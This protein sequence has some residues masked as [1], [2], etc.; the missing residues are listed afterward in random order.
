MSI[1]TLIRRLMSSLLSI[2]LLLNLIQVTV[3]VKALGTDQSA[4]PDVVRSV[5]LS[6]RLKGTSTFIDLVAPYEI[7]DSTKI[8][9]LHARY[10]F[11]LLDNVDPVSGEP[12]RTMEGGDFYLIDLPVNVQII[13]PVNGVILG[14]D[15]RP[16]ANY[17]FT[18]KPDSSWQIK[19]EFTTYIDDLNEFEIHG[20]MEFD[21]ILDLSAVA[22]GTTT[23][24]YI[25]IDNENNLEIEVTKPVPAPTTPISLTKTITSYTTSTRDLVWNI[26]MMPDIGKFSGTTFTD[27]IDPALME[28]RSLRHGAVNLV[29][30]TDYTYDPLSGL[31]TY[32]I[33]SGRDGLAFQNIILTT[34]VK[35]SVYGTLTPTL[36]NNQARLTGGDGFV[37]LVSNTATQTIT[38]NWFTKSGSVVQGNRIQW[39]FDI[40]ANTQLMTNAV[41]T[42]VLS[43]NLTL[44]V[45]SVRLGASVVPVYLDAHTPLTAS[46]VYAVLSQHP[47]GTSTLQVFLPRGVAAASTTRQTL[48]L[49]TSVASPTV[50]TPA[51]P[52][53]ANSAT[54]TGDL[55]LEDN[56]LLPLPEIGSGPISVAV[57]HV[58]LNKTTQTLSAADRRNGT[59]TWLLSVASNLASYGRATIVDTLPNDQDYLADEIY[60]GATKLDATTNPSAIISADGRTLTI[61]F[62]D[63]M[64]WTTQQVISVKTKIKTESYGLNVNRDFLNTARAAIY[65][66]TTLA[67]LDAMSDTERIRIQNTVISK[68]AQVYNGNTTRQGENPRLNFQITINANLMPLQDLIVTD[69]LTR[70]ITEFKRSTENTFSVISGLEW[71]YVEDSLRIVRSAGTLDALDLNAI[72]AN[73]E[74]INDVLTVDFGSGVA[75]NDRYTLTFT[76]EVDVESHPI[77][78]TNG[79]LRVRGNVGGVQALGLRSGVVQSTATG[80]S[81][82]IRNEILGK[83]GVHSVAEQQAVWT[84]NLNQ[85]RVSL[86]NTRVVDMLPLGLTLDPTSIKLYTNVIGTN[87]NFVTGNTILTQGVEVPF[88]YTYL[89]ATGIGNEGRYVLSVN[90]PD[91]RTAYILRFATDVSPTLL[92]K[93]ITNEAYFIGDETLPENTN[94]TSL[95]FSSSS[96]GGSVTKASVTVRKTSKDTGLNVD[97]AQF[98]LHW[99][100]DGDPND[101]VFVRTL[102]T[103]GGTVIFRGLTRGAIYTITET[104]APD[105]YLLDDPTPITVIPPATGTADASSITIANTPI[106]HGSWVPTAIKRLSGRALTETFTFELTDGTQALYGG[107]SGVTLPNGTANVTFSPLAGVDLSGITKFS[108]DHTFAESDPVGTRHLVG[109]SSLILRE[110]DDQKPGYTYDPTELALTLTVYN[111]KGTSDLILI[112]TDASGTV[113]TNDAGVFLTSAVPVFSNTYAA[114][115]SF[116]LR[117]EK[118]LFNHALALGQ[119]TFELYE[120]DALIATTTNGAGSAQGAFRYS[121]PIVFEALNFT[122][123][124]VGTKTYRLIEKATEAPGYASDPAEFTVV[125]EVSDNGDGT[126]SSTVIDLT[127]TFEGLT[128]P[129]TE[130]IFNNTYTT[131]DVQ[132]SIEAQKQL[133]GRPLEDGQ[134]TFVVDEVTE[135]GEWVAEIQRMTNT[136]SRIEVDAF[137]Y[138]QAQVGQVFHYTIR[139]LNDAQ[140]GYR[141]DESVYLIR[142]EVIDQHDGT[143]TTQTSITKNGDSVSAILFTNQYLASADLTLSGTKILNGRPLVDQQFDFMVQEVE[144]ED[145]VTIGE[146][147]IISHDALGQ[148]QFMTW[149]FTQA[150]AGKTLR[151]RV[152]EVDASIP[153]FIYDPSIYVITITVTDNGDGTL[154]LDVVKEIDREGQR[155]TTDV[156]HFN[157]TYD[158]SLIEGLPETGDEARLSWSWVISAVGVVLWWLSRKRKI[159]PIRS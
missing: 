56:A 127:K 86:E 81:A 152:S 29:M 143:L 125:I 112:V 136:G 141:Y 96:G 5:E 101:P 68:T 148:I 22:E 44:D 33:P 149:T 6:Y 73:A 114:S 24:I 119:F 43:A 37:D 8:D 77:F 7:E 115:G 84:I 157:N 49:I 36:I 58:N 16:L 122:M 13:A 90:L 34:R 30:G 87:G 108:D 65:S 10:R 64:A 20:M 75:V 144:G 54:F 102:G 15:S 147:V 80:N 117:A 19:I 46:E 70:L 83:T 53:Y 132:F 139:E 52:Q 17:S 158:E 60:W 110:V 94:S 14:N 57:P 95:T 85:H 88:T 131:S 92:G 121:A 69:D 133:N 140:A 3:V 51:D 48:T 145:N 156:I 25:P 67:E 27:V 109:V 123:A 35:R 104:A 128:Y 9:R 1:Q 71:T 137:T 2:V 72:A 89:P 28:L 97:G 82:E 124:D 23:T 39:S 26:K 159:Q 153:G 12:Q 98:T 134:F 146:P 99:L 32:L 142:V 100:R 106:K 126:L 113:L 50:L 45:A 42:D 11:E 118:V 111:E 21:F 40:N 138:T 107:I 155:E 61:T 120:D 38:P 151:Y 62:T 105:G 55:V 76:V 150:E 91:N 63:A 93:Q 79:V 41:I 130:L 135:D 47:D 78:E 59:I 18:Q 4:N 103:T 31:V 154:T 66:E 129:V 74:V 116:E